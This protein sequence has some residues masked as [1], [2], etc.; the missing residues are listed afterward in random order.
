MKMIKRFDYKLNNE[1]ETYDLA[2]KLGKHLFKGA[3]IT[4]EGHLGAGKTTFTKGIAKG[5][6]IEDPISSPTFTIIKEY[7]G[8]LPLYH[9]DAYRIENGEEDLGF[10]DY[11][12]GDGVTVIE[13]GSKIKPQI[14]KERLHIVIYR[15]SETERLLE[16]FPMTETY[17]ALCEVVFDE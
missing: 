6:G 14:P 9:I 3:I 11:F 13:W 1:Q 10:D 12:H 8:H 17:S 5:L 7:D 2:Y 15:L 16:V 4:L